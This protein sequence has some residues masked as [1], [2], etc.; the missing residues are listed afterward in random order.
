MAIFTTV[1]K[2]FDQ[3]G[4]KTRW[5]YI[6]IPTDVT[7]EL[8][9]G[10]KTSFRVKGRLDH[11]PINLVA[12]LPLKRED[13]SGT[14]FMMPINA[15]MRRGLGKEEAGTSIQV[16]LDV[17]HSPI[18]ISA[19]LL[20]CLQDDPV[21]LAHFNTLSKSHQN[22]FSNWIE[23]AKTPATKDDR[24]VKSIRGLSMGMD[25]GEMIRCFKKQT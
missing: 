16:E 15:A 4:D 10:R 12:L 3:K 9:P 19:D 6:E 17:D 1:L 8:Q 13:G 24:I 20:E 18:P 22:Y 5:T 23:E 21:A 14:G 25:F 2:K 7:D 11:F